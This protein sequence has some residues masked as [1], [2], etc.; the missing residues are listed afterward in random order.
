MWTCAT[1]VYTELPTTWK[2]GS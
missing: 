1:I 2:S